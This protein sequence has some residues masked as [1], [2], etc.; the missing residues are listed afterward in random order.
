M[1]LQNGLFTNFS[2]AV[3]SGLITDVGLIVG[4]YIRGK[5]NTTDLWRLKVLIPLMIGFFIGGYLGSICHRNMGVLA[6]Y[7]PIIVLGTT[8]SI[9]TGLRLI[10]QMKSTPRYNIKYEKF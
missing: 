4:H 5:E 1:G 9:W 7:F 8:G 6:M 10:S 2:G 3:V